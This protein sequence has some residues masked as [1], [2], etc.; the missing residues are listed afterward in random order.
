MREG[1]ALAEFEGAGFW[2]KSSFSG[3]DGGACCEVALL[4]KGV[5][6]RDSKWRRSS[7]VTFSSDAWRVAVAS[8]FSWNHP[9]C[10]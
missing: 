3:N 9:G 10:E 8:L 5:M 6:V 7:V 2:R 1:A 4:P